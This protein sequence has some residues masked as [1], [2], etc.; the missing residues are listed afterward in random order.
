MTQTALNNAEVAPSRVNSKYTPARILARLRTVSLLYLLMLP[1]ILSMLIFS[2]Y[3]KLDVVIKAFYRWEPGQIE[4]FIGLKNFQDAL[5]DPL[6]WNSFQLV[7]ILL[8]ANLVKMWPGIIT[9]IALH[10][11]ASNRWRYIFQVAFVIPMVIP[12]L[13]WLLIWKSFYEPDFGILNRFL[14]LTGGMHLLSWLDGTKD[15]PGVMPNIAEAITPIINGPVTWLFAS[16]WGMLTFGAVA[17]TCAARNVNPIGNIKRAGLTVGLAFCTFMVVQLAGQDNTTGSAI[18]LIGC[19]LFLIGIA[20]TDG[21]AWLL[22]TMWM[23]AG[24]WTCQGRLYMLPILVA[25]AEVINF[26][27]RNMTHTIAAK[28]IV[29]WIGLAVLV[30]G[31]LLIG[32]GKIWTVPTGQ[33]EFGSPAWLGNKDLVLPAV[34]FWGFPWVGTVGVLIYLAGLQQISND[35]YEAAELDGVGPIRRVFSIELP[36]IMTQ[37]RINLIFMTIGTLTAYE[38]FLILLGPAGGPGNKGM[39]PGLYM[40]QKAFLSGR[41]GYACALG[42]VL[43]ML[44]LLLTIIYQRYV[45]VEK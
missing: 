27:V 30:V 11:L 40:Y 39:V 37:V 44:V 31:C 12:G 13:V 22:W 34:I 45:K 26:A 32:F 28:D 24:S 2:Y 8:V 20:R 18:A 10:R 3:P 35:V 6:F 7:I 15:V 42:M 16:V 38:F 14:N 23:L 5:S 33:F 21:P 9:A 25:V 43:F 41:F 29:K 19:I 4:E 17:M 1:T 36:L